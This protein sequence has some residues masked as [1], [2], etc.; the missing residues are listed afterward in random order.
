MAIQNH[1]SGKAPIKVGFEQRA[2]GGEETDLEEL[3]VGAT[4][5]EGKEA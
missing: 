2:H 1:V 5:E 3:R 4:L